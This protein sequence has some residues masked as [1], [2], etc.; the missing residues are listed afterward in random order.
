M[1]A[2]LLVDVPCLIIVSLRIQ[3]PL[4]LPIPAGDSDSEDNAAALEVRKP[5]I[6]LVDVVS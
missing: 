3:E 1:P 6:S 4:F 5:A 2:I